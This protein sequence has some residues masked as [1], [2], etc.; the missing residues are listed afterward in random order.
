MLHEVALR[1]APF[2][3]MNRRYRA[4]RRAREAR[5]EA[6]AVIAHDL[7]SPIATI[8][9]QSALLRSQG[10]GLDDR[11]PSSTGVI[12]RAVA[13]MNRIIDGIL[14]ISRLDAG[15]LEI[16]PAPVAVA[17]LLLPTVSSHQPLVGSRPVELRASFPE[18]LPHVMADR[19]RVCRVLDNLIANALK[20]TERGSISIGARL[21]GDRVVVSV[22]DTGRGVAPDDLPRLFE[23]FW[24][25]RH[26]RH[27]GAGL[28]LAIVKG[29]VE[30]HGGRVWAESRHGVGST[31]FFT[32]PVAPPHV[33]YRS[34][35]ERS[36]GTGLPY[37]Q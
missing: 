17:D 25:A 19:E 5:D 35:V 18:D 14:E 21:A 29:I 22:A 7:R 15:V 28:G 6:L 9:A 30:A 16:E 11:S 8:V 34:E 1:A 10:P 24:Q 32:L 31:F 13:R 3:E 26:S 27:A 33:P 12:A 36:G 2:V 37:P 20:F 23:R 4:E